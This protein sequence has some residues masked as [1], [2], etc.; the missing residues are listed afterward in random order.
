MRFEGL[1]GGNISRC[2]ECLGGVWNILDR[3]LVDRAGLIRMDLGESTLAMAPACIKGCWLTSHPYTLCCDRCPRSLR[4][5]SRLDMA[6]I[7]A[8]DSRVR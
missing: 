5:C 3:V 7:F 8:E 4:S 1:R 2:W 6:D